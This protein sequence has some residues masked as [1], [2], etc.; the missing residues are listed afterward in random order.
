MRFLTSIGSL[1]LV[2]FLTGWHPRENSGVLIFF[3]NI[4]DQPAAALAAGQL[5]SLVEQNGMDADTTSQGTY[6]T[7]DS[8]K[9]YGTL[10]FL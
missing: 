5:L 7:E 1:L 8:L 9:T 10:I 3:K 6:I 2:L 4:T